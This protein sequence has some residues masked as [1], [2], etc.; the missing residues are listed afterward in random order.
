M[1]IE[2]SKNFKILPFAQKYNLNL[3][4]KKGDNNNC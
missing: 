1:N 2:K 3:K 4:N